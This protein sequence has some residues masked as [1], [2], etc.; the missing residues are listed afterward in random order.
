M[1]GLGKL[2]GFDDVCKSDFRLASRP[3][4]VSQEHE[5]MRHVKYSAIPDL[6]QSGSDKGDALARI[7][8]GRQTPSTKCQT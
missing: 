3:V 1:R 8:H 2:L 4:C 5:N 7:T 6:S